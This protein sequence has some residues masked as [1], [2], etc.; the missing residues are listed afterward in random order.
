MCVGGAAAQQNNQADCCF[1]F[2]LLI[3]GPLPRS[4]SV[5]CNIFGKTLKLHLLQHRQE[6]WGWGFTLQELGRLK[7]SMCTINYSCCIGLNGVKFFKG[8]FAHGKAPLMWVFQGSE[9][10]L[11]CQHAKAHSVLRRSSTR[12]LVSYTVQRLQETG[13]LL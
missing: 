9:N 13:C 7:S 6:G 2:Y 10:T 3:T 8:S 4:L 11:C 5:S 12:L 1:F